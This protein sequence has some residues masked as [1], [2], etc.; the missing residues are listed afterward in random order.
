MAP[1]WK[2]DTRGRAQSMAF[3]WWRSCLPLLALEGSIYLCDGII[4][5]DTP[6][7]HVIPP[8]YPQ[9]AS[10]R[11][12]HRIPDWYCVRW[13]EGGDGCRSFPAVSDVQRSRSCCNAIWRRGEGV[14]TYIRSRV[15]ASIIWRRGEGG[16][17]LVQHLQIM[18][19]PGPFF[20]AYAG[21]SRSAL[22]F[23]AQIGD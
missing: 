13:L 4:L 14:H 20:S 12:L 2:P 11:H 3:P 19:A 16:G 1:L 9:C 23:P 8:A 21:I 15:R 22:V 17:N 10:F 6:C 5:T 7:A 18:A